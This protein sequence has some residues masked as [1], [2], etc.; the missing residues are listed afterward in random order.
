MTYTTVS[1]HKTAFTD[2]KM[3]RASAFSV[4]AFAFIIIITVLMLFY[5]NKREVE[6]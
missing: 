1:H 2:M 3:G 4:M 6:L 5:L